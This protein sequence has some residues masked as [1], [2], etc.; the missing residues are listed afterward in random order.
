[1]V[2]LKFLALGDVHAHVVHLHLGREVGYMVP[3]LCVLLV[4][5]G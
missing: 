5:C 4:I 3:L 1:M 2:L